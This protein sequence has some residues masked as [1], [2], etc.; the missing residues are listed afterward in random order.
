MS[1]N[2]AGLSEM[3]NK[4]NKRCNSHVASLVLFFYHA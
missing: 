4:R 1:D 3:L 2:V